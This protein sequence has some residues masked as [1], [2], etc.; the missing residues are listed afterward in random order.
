MRHTEYEDT[1]EVYNFDSG[2][3]VTADVLNF[4]PEKSLT[5]SINRAIKVIL[6]YQERG[7]K[8]IGSASGFEFWSD[9]P[10]GYTYR[11]NR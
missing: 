7:R 2:K 1:C 6:Q 3:T 10:K 11:T 5:V 9:G 8:Y 4:Q